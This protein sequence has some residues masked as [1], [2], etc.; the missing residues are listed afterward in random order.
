MACIRLG[1]IPIL[2]YLAGFE[3]IFALVRILKTVEFVGLEDFPQKREI[4]YFMVPLSGQNQLLFHKDIFS[5]HSGQ[6][7]FYLSCW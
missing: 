1:P 3:F 6:D 7:I 5:G 2:V 4:F